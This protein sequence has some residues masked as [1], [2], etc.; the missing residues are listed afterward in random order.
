VSERPTSREE[1]IDSG[2]AARRPLIL[3]ACMIA[4]FTAAVE[5]TI[6]ATAMPT[7][8]ADLGGFHLFSWV[9]AVYLLTQAVTIPIYG[10]LADLYGR[11]RMFAIG[12]ALFLAGSA[13]CGFA[14]SMT[15][16]I[17][18]RALQ[19][20]GAGAIMPIATTIIGDIYTPA[21]RAQVQGW[22]SSVWG[23]S[24]IIGPALGA[25]LVQHV[26]W[27]VVF[28]INLPIGA[29]ATAMLAALL[30]ERLHRRDH[31]ID[32]FGAVLLMLGTAAL[33]LALVQAD[34]LGRGLVLSLL[35]ASV[36]VLGG[37]IARQ[38]TVPEPMLPL[39]LWRQRII[40]AGNIGALTI[41]IVMMGVTA[42]L[43]TYV[44]GVMDRSATTAGMALAVMSVGWPLASAL[45]GRMM[46]RTPYRTTAALGGVALIAGNLVLISMHLGQGLAWPIVGAFLIGAGMGFCNTTYV[47]AVQGA[48]GW[49]ERGVATSSNMFMRMVGQSLGASLYGAVLN[50]GIAHR[51]PNAGDAVE[52][53]MDPSHRA[54]LGATEADRLIAAVAGSLQEVYV[55]GG[56][57]AAVVLLL[58]LGLPKA[59]AV[60]QEQQRKP[61]TEGAGR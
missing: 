49:S 20:F 52:V 11:K 59:S 14:G 61:R 16:L 54:S 40:V 33:M 4:M 19:G 9:F 36:V 27:P 32:Y 28:W 34:Q 21:E 50:I 31:R 48:V 57:L 41:G 46:V 45:C 35:A 47:V 58:A 6:V 10:R 51:L 42:F 22:L 29:A 55:I 56:V 8:V 3:A 23:V 2:V 5:A 18:F 53:L 38:R 13:L 39:H 30:H 12:M 24:A 44:Q 43:P 7:I 26:G 1:H 37:F 60:A 15:A 17:A 25:F